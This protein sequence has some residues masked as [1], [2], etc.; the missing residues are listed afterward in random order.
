[1]D[2]WNWFDNVF[3]VDKCFR[4]ITTIQ[5]N[6]SACPM[7]KC[8]FPFKILIFDSQWFFSQCIPCWNFNSSNLCSCGQCSACGVF[9]K[10]PAHLYGRS[11]LA[12]NMR[13]AMCNVHAHCIFTCIFYIYI[14]VY[15]EFVE[16]QIEY[17]ICAFMCIDFYQPIYDQFNC[18]Q[19]QFMN[20]W[21][22]YRFLNRSILQI[23]FRAMNFPGFNRPKCNSVWTI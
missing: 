20:N 2:K 21:I 12:R 9:D 23:F 22:T 7:D 4:Q 6:P 16:T 19:T 18:F 15:I 14:C 3:F 8:P 5:S 13:C 17:E 11:W 1:M 10:M